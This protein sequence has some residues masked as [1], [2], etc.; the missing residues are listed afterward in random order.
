MKQLVMKFWKD[1]SGAQM[2]EYA[3]LLVLIGLFVAGVALWLSGEIQQAFEKT[4]LCIRDAATA[5]SS[6]STLPNCP[7][8]SAG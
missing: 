4:G 5:T 8:Y 7:G 6:S 1:E 3:L 2:A